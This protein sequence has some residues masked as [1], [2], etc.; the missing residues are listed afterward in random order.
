MLH[1]GCYCSQPSLA[2]ADAVW[3]AVRDMATGLVATH[4][5]TDSATGRILQSWTEGSSAE[6]Y[7]EGLPAEALGFA[8]RFK[9]IDRYANYWGNKAML[10]LSLN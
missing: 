7:T 1:P 4:F 6:K 9:E 5:I 3:I 10:V 8:K 2:T